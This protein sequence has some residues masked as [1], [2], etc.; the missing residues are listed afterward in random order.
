MGHDNGVVARVTLQTVA[1][2]VGVS[3]TTVSNAY[4]RPDQRLSAK[5]RV[6]LRHYHGPSGCELNLVS[7]G[8]SECVCCECFRVVRVLPRN[9][10]LQR[11]ESAFARYV[12]FTAVEHV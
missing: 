8:F 5:L 10:D 2:R 4:N 9:G 11:S 6:R 3:R 12:E 1:D 7:D